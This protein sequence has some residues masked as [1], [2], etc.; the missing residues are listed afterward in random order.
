MKL[1]KNLS[2]LMIFCNFI[3]PKTNFRIFT[4]WNKML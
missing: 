2:N 3:C 1:E 4:N